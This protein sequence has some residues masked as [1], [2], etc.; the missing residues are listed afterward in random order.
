M[1][2]NKLHYYEGG[3]NASSG[4]AFSREGSGSSSSGSSASDAEPCRMSYRRQHHHD[5]NACDFV[6]PIDDPEAL[7]IA[8]S[9]SPNQKS[10]LA[11][12]MQALGPKTV[13]DGLMAGKKRQQMQQAAAAAASTTENMVTNG[14]Q[15]DDGAAKATAEYS[16]SKNGDGYDGRPSS[17]KTEGDPMKNI[18]LNNRNHKG[19][20]VA[21]SATA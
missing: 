10:I 21:T 1:P 11:H 5:Y 15:K 3:A 12:V 20:D 4:E 16:D 2:G 9:L 13:W 17:S 14:E 7:Q 8:A 6:A 19:D 18:S